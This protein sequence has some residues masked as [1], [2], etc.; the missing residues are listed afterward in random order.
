MNLWGR[1]NVL[2]IQPLQNMILYIT[3]IYLKPNCTKFKRNFLVDQPKRR[4]TILTAVWS[5]LNITYSTFTAFRKRHS[6]FKVARSAFYICSR[7]TTFNT[8]HSTFDIQRSTFNIQYST[9]DILN[10]VF[11]I[12]HM[13]LTFETWLSSSDTRNAALDI[14]HS[15]FNIRHSAFDKYQ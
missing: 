8:R 5:K 2:T 4:T 3:T 13:T 12:R 14:E 1:E 9:H 11:I 6:T 7:H 15:T 10:S